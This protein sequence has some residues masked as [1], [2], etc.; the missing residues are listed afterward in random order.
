MQYNVKFH[1]GKFRSYVARI[2]TPPPPQY[3]AYLITTY[4]TQI[5]EHYPTFTIIIF[6]K[7]HLDTAVY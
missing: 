3:I 6:K 5:P 2:A 4:E 1:Y 7:C